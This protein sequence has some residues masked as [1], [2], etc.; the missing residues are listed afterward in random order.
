MQ[1]EEAQEVAAAEAK[2]RADIARKKAGDQ[3]VG[4][5][6]SIF[7]HV[8]RESEDYI[9]WTR[10]SVYYDD[11]AA[12]VKQDVEHHNRLVLVL[13][14]LLDRSEVFHPHPPWQLWTADG[15][16]AALVLLY[17][18]ARALSGGAPPDFEAY[19]ARLN[20]TL[21]AGSHTVGQQGAWEEREAARENARQRRTGA[22]ATRATTNGSPPTAIPG[23]GH[24]ATVVSVH[25]GRCRFEWYRE[26]RRQRYGDAENVAA[27][28]V[29]ASER[30]CT[31]TPTRRATS[32]SSTTIRAR[33][34]TTCSGRR[35]C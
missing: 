32:S 33:A 31:S 27:A 11:I 16:A 25:R 29:V 4:A 13:Q 12:K 9:P 15:M 10:E 24:V 5:T 17:D 8:R 28:I 18:D 2:R 26:K 19:R 34:P 21:A 35:C 30:C 14:G 7:Y 22:S 1:E 3:S 23:P 6:D 20:A